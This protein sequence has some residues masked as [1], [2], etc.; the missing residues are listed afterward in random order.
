MQWIADAQAVAAVGAVLTDSRLGAD[1]AAALVAIGGDAAAGQLRA[2]WPKSEGASRQTILH[3]LAA[4]SHAGAR[5]VGLDVF[6]AALGLPDVNLRLIAAWALA[7]AADA[8]SAGALL[9]LADAP[10]ADSGP[11][12]ERIKA[13]SAC[14]LLAE[15]LAAADNKKVAAEVY[16]HL[17]DTRQAAVEQHVRDAAGK[18]LAALES[19]E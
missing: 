15:R 3:A 4:L 9:K 13:T 14:M 10:L 1:A 19:A 18:A 16:R 17:R 5:R 7:E 11:S 12:I 2:A 6:R 8:D